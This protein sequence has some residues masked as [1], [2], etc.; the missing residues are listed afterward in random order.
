MK[1]QLTF[2]LLSVALLLVSACGR[3]IPP[4]W[5]V[6]YM[7]LFNQEAHVRGVDADAFDTEFVIVETIEGADAII[8]MCYY[9]DNRVEVEEKFWKYAS[10]TEREILIF[11]ELGHCALKKGH[12]D[13][14]IMRPQLLNEDYYLRHRSQLL[15]DLF[16]LP[17]S[18]YVWSKGDL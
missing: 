17:R 4:D 12:S 15:D 14:G 11:H 5:A 9:A 16:L 13:S 6:P 7:E 10:D 2:I 18:F 8:G 3:P 1:H